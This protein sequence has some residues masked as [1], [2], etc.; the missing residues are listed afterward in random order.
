[1]SLCPDV[2]T[3]VPS[4]AEALPCP[5]NICSLSPS[6]LK[7]IEKPQ[8]GEFPSLEYMNPNSVVF[9]GIFIINVDAALRGR[10]G[11]GEAREG[12]VGGRGDV[13]EQPDK[14]RQPL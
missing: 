12:W 13:A 14:I 4:V 7:C 10:G 8:P 11:G 5:F 1:M 3:H 6:C 9:S 2:H